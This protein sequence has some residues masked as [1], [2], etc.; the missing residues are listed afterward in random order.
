MKMN[1]IA[2]AHELPVVSTLFWSEN[3]STSGRNRKYKGVR[4]DASV[5]KK[6]GQGPTRSTKRP[7]M[8]LL[9]KK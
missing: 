2:L 5:A 3:S 9:V 6:N 7:R 8:A 1:K 4:A